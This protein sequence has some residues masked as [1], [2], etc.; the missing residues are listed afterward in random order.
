MKA[1]WVSLKVDATQT[2][3][4]YKINRSH[5]GIHL[6]TILGGI[7][8]FADTFTGQ[9]VTETMLVKDVN[10]GEEYVG[11]TA[12][13]LARISPNKAYL[14]IPTRPPAEKWVQPPQEDILNRAYQI[15]S[16][17][18]D[19]AEYLIGYEGNEFTTSGNVVNDLLST[20]AVH[21]MRE[22][23]V[24]ELLDKTNESWS[25]IERLIS[26][27]DLVKVEYQGQ[28]FFMKSLRSS[29][30]PHEIAV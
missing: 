24:Q 28:A 11:K 14:S 7:V 3:I 26:Q 9:L 10:D 12:D 25:I 30:P 18:V 2:G 8:E 4:W 17:R 20:T 21:P 16:E 5:P 23:A 22:D 13:F 27:H 1:D 15:L 29:T 19:C 6:R